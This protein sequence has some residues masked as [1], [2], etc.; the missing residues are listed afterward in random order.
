M[1]LTPLL[2][3]LAACSGDSGSTPADSSVP[4]DGAIDA[5]RSDASATIDAPPMEV[6]SS[7]GWCQVPM[8]PSYTWAMS[9]APDGQPWTVAYGVRTKT[10]FAWVHH[11]LSWPDLVSPFIVHN[12]LYSVFALSSTDVW[13]GGR[14]GYVG[15][16]NGAQWQQYRPA[17][18]EAEAIWGAA[19][20]DVWLL[21][22]S[23]LRYHWNGTTLATMPTSNVRY[24]GAWGTSANDVWGFGETVIDSKYYPAVDHFDGTAWQ[25]IVLP[26]FGTVIAFWNSGPNDLYA[27]ISL[28]GTTRLVHGDGTTWSAPIGPTGMQVINVWGRAANDV[29]IVG[30]QG[31]IA[32]FDGT[33][34]TMSATGTTK[35]LTELGGNAT[36]MW[37]AGDGVALRRP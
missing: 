36:V 20:N 23:G 2:A 29:W 22:D 14:Q 30:R 33:S 37:A 19:T 1:R 26:G 18:P 4:I 27:V 10:P 17:A 15:H 5:R 6:C 16:Y 11:D 21:Y 32:R 8:S 34:W 31:A 3:L 24:L 25:R 7:A 12:E 35:T 9:V 13:V 28:N